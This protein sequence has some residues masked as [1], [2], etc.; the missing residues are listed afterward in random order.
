MYD[1]GAISLI[2]GQEDHGGSTFCG[3]AVLHLTQSLGRVL[4]ENDWRR[5]LTYWC[6]SRQADSAEGGGLLG[7]PNKAQDTCYSYWIGGTLRL[8]ESHQLLDHDALFAFVIDCQTDMGGFGKT[9][10]AYPD[11]LHSFYSLAWLSLST[12]K[13]FFTDEEST[14]DKP[15]SPLLQELDCAFGLGKGRAKQFEI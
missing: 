7:R 2:P 4:D 12:N 5:E 11:L 15:A 3:V 14:P 8:L 6:V 9:V 1:G 10:G 13:D